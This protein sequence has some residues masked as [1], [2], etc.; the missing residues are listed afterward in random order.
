MFNFHFV[1]GEPPL[2]KFCPQTQVYY[3]D[4]LHGSIKIAWNEPIFKDNV[5]VT[6]ISRTNV[7]LIYF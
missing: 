3:R 1:E 2:V 6:E 4:M 5:N 7:S